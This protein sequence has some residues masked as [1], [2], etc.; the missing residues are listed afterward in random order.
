MAF[1]LTCE[2]KYLNFRNLKVTKVDESKPYRPALEVE[3]T[4]E[5]GSVEVLGA[6]TSFFMFHG[7]E[8][9][10]VV[11]AA[12]CGH[13]K[14]LHFDGTDLGS[15][16]SFGSLKELMEA[17]AEKMPSCIP[18]E[19]GVSAFALE[20]DRPMGSEGIATMDELRDSGILRKDDVVTALIAR[21]TVFALNK[22]S[23]KEEKEAFVAKFASDNPDC[24][25]QFTLVRGTVIVPTVTAPKQPTTKLFLVFGPAEGGGYKTLYTAAPGR[26]MP[27]HPNPAQFHP[28][29]GGTEGKAFNE[30]LN[31][32]YETVMLKS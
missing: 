15:R 7:G 30:A 31:S 18:D 17:V 13:I 1:G 10:L 32:W 5:D 22:G 8:G 2:S 14:E 27:R 11:S 23:T 3:V 20:M 12:A 16:F 28:E 24:R 25:V 4:L 21:G 26:W 6:N 9:G 29:E 19:P